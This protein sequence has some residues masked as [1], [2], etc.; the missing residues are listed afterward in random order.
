MIRK[1]FICLSL[2]LAMG[3]LTGCMAGSPP[4]ISSAPDSQAGA[5][6]GRMI[7]PYAVGDAQVSQGFAPLDYFPGEAA[8]AD[9]VLIT[10]TDLMSLRATLD[11]QPVAFAVRDIQVEGNQTVLTYRITGLPAFSSDQSCN[12]QI[13]T[14]DGR[15][16]L[17]G[18]VRFTL[19]QPYV[20]DFDVRSTALLVKVKEKHLDLK[21]MSVGQLREL[22]FD[23]V[24]ITD[25]ATLRTELQQ[26]GTLA[27]R[28]IVLADADDND[29]DDDQDTR[30]KGHDQ[31]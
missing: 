24:L 3:P 2:S 23:P 31:D 16:L 18:V 30:G 19:G 10:R 11:D 4:F 14:R 20:Y 9:T 1:L 29:H 5:L 8:N 26:R 12:V 13:L 28:V 6:E 17:G 21:H 15:P 22:E 25:M 7:L 27:P